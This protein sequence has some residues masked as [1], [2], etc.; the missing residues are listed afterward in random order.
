MLLTDKKIVLGSQSPRR[1]M[2]LS[3]IV[4]DYEIRIIETNESYPDDLA[5]P[6]VAAHISEAKAAA[7]MPSVTNE[8]ILTADTIVAYKNKIYGKPKDEADALDII[9]M[10]ANEVHTV[11]TAVT[12]LQNNE[13]DTFTTKTDVK[14][15]PISK[16]EASYYVQKDKP[17]DKAGSYGIQDWIGMA[18]VEWIAGSYTNILGLPVAQLYERLSKLG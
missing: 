6:K 13:R 8:I 1:S 18:K 2:L 14:F 16:E 9:L 7:H 17:M 5:I 4:E 12:I 15:A 11:Y 10:L 3:Q